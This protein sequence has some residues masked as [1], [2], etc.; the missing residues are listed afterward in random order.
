MCVHQCWKKEGGAACLAHA[1]L[2]HTKGRKEGGPVQQAGRRASRTAACP[3]RCRGDGWEK[4]KGLTEGQVF[5]G[6]YSILQAHIGGCLAR[7]T[8]VKRV[9]VWK[10][11]LSR[12]AGAPPPAAAAGPACPPAAHPAGGCHTPCA[13][14]GQPGAGSGHTVPPQAHLQ[15]TP[16]P[17]PAARMRMFPSPVRLLEVEG[18]GHGGGPGRLGGRGQQ[19]QKRGAVALSHIGAAGK[20]LRGAHGVGA[21]CS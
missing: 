12:L 19:V 11:C 21:G 18:E 14:R 6:G 7:A 13:Q 2:P 15:H 1:R 17:P 20:R 5:C 3:S 4:G 9:C 10:G 8:C 16:P